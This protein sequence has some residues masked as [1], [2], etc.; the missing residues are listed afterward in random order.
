MSDNTKC[1]L[2]LWDTGGQERFDGVVNSSIR[3][4]DGIVV[5][6]DLTRRDS[7]LHMRDWIDRIKKQVNLQITE[8]QNFQ[9]ALAS[10][11]NL[12]GS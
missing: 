1:I 9:A 12:S 10:L 5:V 3:N 8:E 2:K 11:E 7:F 4:A 6:F